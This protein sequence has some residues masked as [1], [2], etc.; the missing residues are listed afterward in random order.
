MGL[1]RGALF[2]VCAILL[3]VS[4]LS[5]NTFWSISKSLEYDNVKVELTP[6]V[7]DLIMQQAGTLFN[8]EQIQFYCQNNTDS[9]KLTPD[10]VTFEIPCTSVL[11]GSESI[12][13]SVVLQMI[14]SNYYKEYECNFWQCSFDP[15]FHLVSQKAQD[16]WS[17]WFYLCLVISIVLA[18]ICLI[19]IENK[20]DYPFI[21]GGLLI[22]SS[23][24]FAKIEWILSFMGDWEFIKIVAAFFSKA[25]TVF[26]ITFVTGIF[27]I[28]LGVALKFL[29]LSKVLGNVFSVNKKH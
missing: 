4:L 5:M 22:I 15:P 3:F 26:L 18:V 11:E 25:Y 10:D 29:G 28:L 2:T 13:T 20:N 1:I 14:E 7:T 23:L 27:L 17:E 16:Y 8:I 9:F 6:I 19:L 12:V 24:I 21:L